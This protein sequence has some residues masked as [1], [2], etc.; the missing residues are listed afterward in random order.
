MNTGR[1]KRGQVEDVSLCSAALEAQFI[2]DYKGNQTKLRY[3]V[4][5]ILNLYF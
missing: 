1:P 2:N 4:F 3:M 5:F